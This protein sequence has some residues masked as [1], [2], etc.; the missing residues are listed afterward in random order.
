MA[1]EPG[2]GV[3]LVVAKAVMESPVL[4]VVSACLHQDHRSV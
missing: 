1:F 3:N 2:N 4:P